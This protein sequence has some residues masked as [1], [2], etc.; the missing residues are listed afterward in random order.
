MGVRT[1]IAGTLIRAAKA[2]GGLQQPEAMAQAAEQ[3]SQMGPD[4]PFSPGEPVQPYDGYSRTPRTLDYQTSYNVAT[5]PRTHE[6]VSFDTL[7]GLVE[8]Y[9]VASLCIW[10]RIDSIRSLDWKLVAADGYNGDVAD[11]IATGM[12]ALRKPDGVH[13]FGT[14][15]A[16]WA[17]DVLAYDA[18]ALFRLRNRAGQ[19][20]GL[21][22]VDGTTLA[23]LLD[24]WGNSPQAPA[25]AYVQ[26]ANGVPWNWLTRD[27]LIYE[28]FRPRNNSPYGNAPLESIILNANTDL[29]FQVY[30]LQRFT[31]G[32]IPEAFASAPES[33]S[34]DQIEQFQGLWDSLMYGD[35][36]QKHQIKWMPGGSSIAWSN[37][38]DFSDVFSLHMMRKSCAAYH[39]VPTDM[40]FTESSNYST[41]ESQADVGHRIGDLPF[42]RHAER[43]LTGF[44]QRDLGLPIKHQFDWGEEQDDRVAQANADDVYLKTGVVGVSEIREMRFGLPEPDGIPVPRFIYT[45]R[46]G[47]I[48]LSSL[49]DVAGPVDEATGAPV[50]GAILPHKEFQLVEGVVPVP[51]PPAPA[52]AEREYGPSAVPPALPLPPPPGV[53]VAPGQPVVPTPVAKEATTGITSGTGI[54][55][56]DGP[57]EDDDDEDEDDEDPVRAVAKE[58]TAF[59][60][61]EKARKRTG[62]WRDFTFEAVDTTTAR[63]LNEA[64]RS[65][66][67]KAANRPKVEAPGLPD[68]IRPAV[69]RR[70]RK[71]L[72]DHLNAV[73]AAWDACMADLSPR[74]LVRDF[75]EDTGLGQK[76]A[77]A[78]TTQQDQD[79]W[80][81][82]AVAA[83][84]AWLQKLYQAKG[85]AALVA[86][87]ELAI[88]A[89]MAEGEADALAAAAARQGVT[90][91]DIAG[92]FASAYGRLEGDPGVSQQAQET[93][94]RIVQGAA[95]DL[96]KQLAEDAGAGKG[97]QDMVSGVRGLLT[98]AVRSV[99]SWVQDGM[100]AAL[101]AGVKGLL[102]RIGLGG[103]T[104]LVNWVTDG[105][106]CAM[107]QD[108]EAGSP[109]APEDVPDYPGHPN[110]QC[111]LDQV[112]DVPSSFFAGLLG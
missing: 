4:H 28:P 14:W 82:V 59:R 13:D 93:L 33:W 95:A 61:F 108:N 109:Y 99:R 110:C 20:V 32:N 78:A 73:Q 62:S 3:V 87:I 34:P 101:G 30:F 85:Y 72:D 24:Y 91:L 31:D 29:R 66:V 39:V 51:P 26:Y 77:K 74:D 21:Q 1:G 25:E 22:P 75:R 36:S 52:L 42:G 107:C 64:G 43:I 63:R 46:A 67:A 100:W 102:S 71:L 70:R 69:I 5:R 106:P 57:G 103:Q 65:A 37:E 60:R 35:Q 6:R 105:N 8:A 23:P 112:S 56:Y 86:A 55:G 54:V 58:M 9:D 38:K 68:S 18:G 17:Y 2:F 49:M 83:A 90:G 88:R 94:E 19:V 53:E 40:G 111:E 81:G 48:P 15:F 10:H 16:K 7:R 41:G 79:W 27:D 12:K 96:G 11:A 92:A 98:G 89:G 104:G 97:Q 44:L 47:P 80:K 45:T 76:V 50:P 84:L